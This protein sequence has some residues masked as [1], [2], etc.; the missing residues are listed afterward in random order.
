MPHLVIEFTDNIKT[1]SNIPELLKKVNQT[2]LTHQDI[3]PI[4]GLR[5]RAIAL[6]DYLV[7]DGS[8]DDAFVHVTLKLGKGRT[9]EQKKV[10][11]EDLFAVIKDHFADLFEKRYLAL[12]ME[13][14]E[15]TNPTYKQNN[16]HHRYKD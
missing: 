10:V 4:G 14:Y 5:S 12:S 8:E 7:A 15:F 16:I 13:L 3:I 9:E 11:C 2:L 6:Q 1:E